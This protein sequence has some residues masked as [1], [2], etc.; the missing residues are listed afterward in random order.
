MTSMKLAIGGVPLFATNGRKRLPCNSHMGNCNRC[1]D[2]TGD[3]QAVVGQL[4][5][6]HF[7]EVD[8]TQRDKKRLQLLIV[9][10]GRENVFWGGE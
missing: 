4:F 3:M 1:K 6:S 2:L 9:R 5:R 7:A 10:R 8:D